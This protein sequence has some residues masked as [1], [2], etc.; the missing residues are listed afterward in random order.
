MLGLLKE[1]ADRT[2]Q[3]RSRVAEETR[4]GKGRHHHSDGAD[5]AA[6]ASHSKGNLKL[7]GSKAEE[8]LFLF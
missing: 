8:A 5:R 3:D 6:S 7:Q 4:P 2:A 1:R